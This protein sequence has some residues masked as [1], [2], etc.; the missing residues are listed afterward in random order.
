MKAIRRLT[1]R[2]SHHHPLRSGSISMPRIPEGGSLGTS[3]EEVGSDSGTGTDV[4]IDANSV[5]F[6]AGSFVGE[7]VVESLFA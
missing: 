5:R 4:G 7:T 1:A 6:F 3:V 2:I